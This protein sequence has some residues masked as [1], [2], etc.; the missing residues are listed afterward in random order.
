MENKDIG[1]YF[2]QSQ[3]DEILRTFKLK[4]LLDL[5]ENS[6]YLLTVED[7]SILLNRSYDYTNREIVSS[8]DFPQPVKV[9]KGKGRVRK[10]FLPSDFIKWQRAN[11]RRIN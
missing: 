3:Y 4:A 8:P 11:I 2:N 5:K 9:E 1:V 10:F 6:P 7:I